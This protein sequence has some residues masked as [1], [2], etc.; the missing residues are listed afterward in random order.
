MVETKEGTMPKYNE[1]A[2][3]EL[4]RRIGTFREGKVMSKYEQLRMNLAMVEQDQ[5]IRALTEACTDKD[6]L[7]AQSEWLKTVFYHPD[8]E[9]EY[10]RHE[11]VV[12]LRIFERRVHETGIT[13]TRDRELADMAKADDEGSG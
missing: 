12:L 11:I 3:A 13:I 4:S 2:E 10:R 7:H 5:P 8:S 6:K 9:F 1:E